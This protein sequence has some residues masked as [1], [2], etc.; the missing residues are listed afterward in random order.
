MIASVLLAILLV[1]SSCS[2]GSLPSRTTT[3]SSVSDP[4]TSEV[5]ET[6]YRHPLDTVDPNEST[7]ETTEESGKS[8]EFKDISEEYMKVLQT[9]DPTS[10]MEKFRI[11]SGDFLAPIFACYVEIFTTL[12]T[13]M[14]YNFGA[15][16]SKGYTEC[17]LD[18]TCRIPNV[19]ACVDLVLADED[20]MLEVSREWVL[21]QVN[22]YNSQTAIDAY[23]NMVNNILLEALRR[24]NEGEFTEKTIYSG[25][26]SFHD[27]GDGDWVCVATPDFVKVCNKDDYMWKLIYL[28]P[29]A[30]YSLVSSTGAVLV[31][32]GTVN[33]KDLDECLSKKQKEIVEE[34]SQ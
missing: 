17:D 25:Y 1:S 2:L 28:D 13:N 18:V 11:S 15:L 5:S 8:K 34:D 12:F 4:E 22:G 20:F 14:D 29:V 27:N 21:A 16:S 31:S 10:V 24:I 26:F 32:E 23:A 7:A 3:D 19:K 33:Q 9:G 6:T 30:E